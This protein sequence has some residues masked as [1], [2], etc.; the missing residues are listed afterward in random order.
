MRSYSSFASFPNLVAT[1]PQPVVFRFDNLY[2]ELRDTTGTALG[3]IELMLSWNGGAQYETLTYTATAPKIHIDVRAVVEYI[4]STGFHSY[5]ITLTIGG[6]AAIDTAWVNQYSSYKIAEGRTLPT[7]LHGTTSVIYGNPTLPAT[8]IYFPCAG[9]YTINGVRTPVTSAGVVSGV[10]YGLGTTAIVCDSH[11]SVNKF[12]F[13]IGGT[14]YFAVSTGNTVINGG[15]TYYEY[16]DDSDNST[17]YYVL[18]SWAEV[19]DDVYNNTFVVIATVGQVMKYNDDTCRI[20]E[21]YAG[22]AQEPTEWIIAI[23]WEDCLKERGVV[24]YYTDTDGCSRTIPGVVLDDTTE[25]GSD[26]YYRATSEIRH[27][28]RRHVKELSRTWRIGFYNVPHGAFLEDVLMSESV[29]IYPVDL[30][31]WTLGDII[32]AVPTTKSLPL[33]DNTNVIVEFQVL[34]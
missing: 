21:K 24:V 16:I 1:V 34:A 7:R 18:S 32:S 22:A 10:Y 25:V 5:D 14:M 11:T 6:T 17:L 9:G 30:A 13:D 4:L 28:A 19:G 8:D 15:I 20:G 29:E 27:T 31:N 26:N 33:I 2:Y 23:K 3:D 12:K